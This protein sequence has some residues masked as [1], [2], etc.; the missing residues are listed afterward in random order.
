LKFF[1]ENKLSDFEDLIE[2]YF[3]HDIHTNLFN[4]ND[5]KNTRELIPGG[6]KIR[7]TDRNKREFI[8]KKCH[9]I[10]VKAV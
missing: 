1:K 4:V 6:S 2:Q 7:V 10:G 5:G 9:F 3:T 8:I